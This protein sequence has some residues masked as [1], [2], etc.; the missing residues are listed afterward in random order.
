MLEREVYKRISLPPLLFSK[1][2]LYIVKSFMSKP[3][4]IT[5][6]KIHGETTDLNSDITDKIVVIERADP[7]YDW[8]FSKDIKGLVTCYGGV[9]SHMS[10]RCAEFGIPAMIG[11]GKEIFN[12]IKN[13]KNIYIDCESEKYEIVN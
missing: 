4:Y 10:I 7:G 6:K 13:S 8:I 2:D 5:N 12:H 9:A 11:C 3:N 1:D